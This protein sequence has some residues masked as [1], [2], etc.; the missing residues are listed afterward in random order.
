MH[1]TALRG[2]A[3]FLLA[4]AALA[5]SRTPAPEGAEVYFIS[6]EDGATLENPVVVRFGLKGMGVAPPAPRKGPRDIIT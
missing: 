6:P 2:V 1:R 3:C 4:T 5:G